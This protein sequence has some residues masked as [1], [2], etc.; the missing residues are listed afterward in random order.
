LNKYKGSSFVN[1]E[2]QPP[3]FDADSMYRELKNKYPVPTSTDKK[4]WQSALAPR[5]NEMRD[6]VANNG[7]I[8][9]KFKQ[10]GLENLI[11][12]LSQYL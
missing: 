8:S 1:V 7:Q 10:S 3:S 4:E 12:K 9:I 2:I 6:Y 11:G 5:W